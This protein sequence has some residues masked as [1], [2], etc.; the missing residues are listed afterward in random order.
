MSKQAVSVYEDLYV[1]TAL[2]R[3]STEKLI[4]HRNNSVEEKSFLLN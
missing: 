2:I 1:S 4:L 3:R